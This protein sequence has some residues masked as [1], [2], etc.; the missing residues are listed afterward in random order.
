M[1][2]RESAQ[3]GPAQE[4]LFEASGVVSSGLKLARV[5]CYA[6]VND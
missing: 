1:Q 2:P 3:V 6:A 5:V 4:A